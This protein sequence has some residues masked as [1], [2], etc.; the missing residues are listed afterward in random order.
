M[1]FINYEFKYKIIFGWGRGVAVESDFFR[2]NPNLKKIS[3]DLQ[4]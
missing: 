4:V 2:K 3:F 1:Y